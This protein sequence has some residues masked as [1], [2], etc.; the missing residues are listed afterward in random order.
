M[1][2]LRDSIFIR[3]TAA[4][5]Y[6]WFEHLDEH[7]LD[8]HP[9]HVTC[10]FPSDRLPGP[11]AKIYIEEILHGKL[12]RFRLH[13]LNVIPNREI[14]YR[15]LPGVDGAFL[16]QDRDGGMQ[17]EAT[18]EFG[19]DIPVLGALVD[20]ALRLSL[21]TKLAAIQQHMHEEGINLRRLLEQRT[22]T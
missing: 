12:H 1:I 8:W 21:A 5:A 7:Y 10:R 15:I 20:L 3:A 17:F 9:D 13:V 4:G 19:W 18:L 11:G 2:T 22:S 16:F 6:N 14:R